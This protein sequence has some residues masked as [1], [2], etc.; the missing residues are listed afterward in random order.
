M[1]NK[2][3]FVHDYTRVGF[4]MVTILTAG[5]RRLFGECRD[6]RVYL[7]PAGELVQRSWHEIPLHQPAIETNTL[8]VMTDHLHG[9]VYV[10]AQLLKPVGA[11]IRGFKIG[12]TSA[13][14]QLLG[15]PD[16]AVWEEGYHDRVIMNADTLRTE[17][18]YIRDNPRRYCVRQAHPD[19]FVKVDLLDSPRLPHCI[20]H[21]RRTSIF[22]ARAGCWCY[23]LSSI[24]A[25]HN[26]S[27]ASVASK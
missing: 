19:L 13:L 1:P 3:M 27:P 12:A 26:R 17:R 16:L 7:S 24:L 21:R 23:R 14:R 18:D 25:A 11:T 2:R 22:A 15:N 4:Y 20:N 6:N 10:K 8:A 9:I 5:R